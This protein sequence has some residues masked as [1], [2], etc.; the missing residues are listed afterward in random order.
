M[1][2]LFFIFMKYIFILSTIKSEIVKI[3]KKIWKTNPIPGNKLISLE[4][5]VEFYYMKNLLKINTKCLHI[6]IN[7]K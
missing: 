7:K 1:I 3:C 4:N 5:L 2:F 6:L